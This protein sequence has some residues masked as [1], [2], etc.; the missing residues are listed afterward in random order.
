MQLT[1]SP[2]VSIAARG[3]TPRVDGMSRQ[4]CMNAWFWSFVGNG[5]WLIVDNVYSTGRIRGVISR[6]Q[7]CRPPT[8]RIRSYCNGS[9]QQVGGELMLAESFS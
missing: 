9:V 4:V 3:A 7:E 2:S 1:F 8:L 5:V 6:I